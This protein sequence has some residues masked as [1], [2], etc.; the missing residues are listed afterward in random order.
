M[1]SVLWFEQENNRVEL[2]H[3]CFRLIAAKEFSGQDIGGGI[4]GGAAARRV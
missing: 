1:R 4:G 2:I 3:H